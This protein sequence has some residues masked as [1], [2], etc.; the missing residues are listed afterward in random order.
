MPYISSDQKEALIA[1]EYPSTPGELNFVL[2]QV[3]IE[4][5]NHSG[6]NYQAHN[7]ILGALAGAQLEWYRR[8][9]APYED[10]KKAE[11]GDVYFAE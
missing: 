4:F 5:F 1:R 7:D 9:V 8:V 3:C 11:N 6:Q 2:T 10:G